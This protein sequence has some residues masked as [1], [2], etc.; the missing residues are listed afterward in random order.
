MK[1]YYYNSND[2]ISIIDFSKN[3]NT[4]IKNKSKNKQIIFLCIGS[5][6]A[7]GDCLGPII[8]SNIKNTLTF[9]NSIYNI[10]NDYII[11]GTLEKPVH[12][13]NLRENIQY[14]YEKYENCFI[15]SIDACLGV[16]EHI[17][18]VTLHNGPLKPGAGVSKQL[19]S[20]GDLSITG[21]V[22]LSYG[23]DESLL[24][25]TRLNTV[26]KLADFISMGIN[27]YIRMKNSDNIKIINS[28]Y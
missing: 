5:D 11:L 23:K 1:S 26:I 8:G 24:Q 4:L 16:H 25:T 3:L 6:R 9:Y 18:Y 19:P 21:I 2:T 22:N 7:T 17:G 14:I 27:N 20:V 13:K 10:K 28:S 15:I 12:A